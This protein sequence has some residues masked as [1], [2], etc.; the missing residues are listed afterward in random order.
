VIIRVSPAF[1]KLVKVRA[2]VASRRLGRRV[3]VVEYTHGIIDVTT[4]LRGPSAITSSIT[5][6]A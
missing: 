4:T 5:E 3:S 1:A 2:A 6:D